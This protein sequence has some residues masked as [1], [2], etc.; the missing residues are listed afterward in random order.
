MFVCSSNGLASGNH[1][2]EAVSHAICEVVERDANALF[3]AAPAAWQESRRVDP[4]TIP[5]GPCRELLDRLDRAGVAV[6]IW[7]ATSDIGIP[8]FICK[9]ADTRERGFAPVI[10]IQASGCHPRREIAVLA[11]MVEAVQGRVTRIAGAREELASGLY[12]AAAT[13]E[14][15]A[16]FLAAAAHAPVRSFSDVA[17]FDSDTVAGDVA[18]EL[19]RLAAASLKQVIVVDLTRPELGLPVVRVVVPGLEGI[20]DYAALLAGERQRRWR[21]QWA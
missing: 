9:I 12:D 21:S 10:P 20:G 2:W 6:M 17:G 7:E 19:Q 14:A 16:R 8:T 15:I 4:A 13:K 1:F 11:A 5:A 3:N 18:W